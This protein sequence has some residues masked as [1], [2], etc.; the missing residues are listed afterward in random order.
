[1]TELHA[2]AHWV[3]SLLPDVSIQMG[4]RW[5]F[6]NDC[7]VLNDSGGNEYSDEE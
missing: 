7:G 3:I 6:G 5:F 1:M 2:E 4:P